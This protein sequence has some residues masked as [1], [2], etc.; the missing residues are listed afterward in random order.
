MAVHFNSNTL[1]SN[2]FLAHP[3]FR[4]SNGESFHLTLCAYGKFKEEKTIQTLTGIRREVDALGYIVSFDDGSHMHSIAINLLEN[5]LFDPDL[6]YESRRLPSRE[7]LEAAIRKEIR[8]KCYIKFFTFSV[9]NK[10]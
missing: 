5:Q 8:E 9:Q 6:D 4:N 1:N 10:V 3:A 7:E 2:E